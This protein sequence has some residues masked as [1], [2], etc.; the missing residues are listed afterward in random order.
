MKQDLGLI[1]ETWKELQPHTMLLL[2]EE[3]EQERDL[4]ELYGRDAYDDIEGNE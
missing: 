1:P 3:D 4:I 2:D